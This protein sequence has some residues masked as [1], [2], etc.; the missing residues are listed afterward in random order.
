MG[1]IYKIACDITNKNYV[2]QKFVWVKG[3]KQETINSIL[4]N[5][6]KGKIL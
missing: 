3:K 1:L 5:K 6:R 2:G 4:K